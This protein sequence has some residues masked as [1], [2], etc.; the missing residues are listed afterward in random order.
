MRK[1]QQRALFSGPGWGLLA[2]VLAVSGCA[3]PAASPSTYA[4]S[5][6]F[7]PA[8]PSAMVPPGEST[9]RAKMLEQE[10]RVA[11]QYLGELHIVVVSAP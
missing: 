6:P 11:M 8:V 10:Y 4:L 7:P 1:V 9:L 2:L 5:G 3:G